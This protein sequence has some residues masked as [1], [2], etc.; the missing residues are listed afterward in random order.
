M[1]DDLLLSFFFGMPAVSAIFLARDMRHPGARA[2]LGWGGAVATVL[3]LVVLVPMNL[4]D[5]TLQTA[6]SACVPG[7]GAATLFNSAQP[8]IRGA[9]FAYILAGPPLA[10]LAYGLDWL[11]RRRT[12]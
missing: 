12:P 3:A 10:I 8:V 5:G 4:C 6:Y 9:A 11:H 1:L 7:P 2:I